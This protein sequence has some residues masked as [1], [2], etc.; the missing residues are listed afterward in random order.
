MVVK[1]NL[2]AL[3][4]SGTQQRLCAELECLCKTHPGLTAKS[5]EAA[6]V[7]LDQ[8]LKD[9]FRLGTGAIIV[10]GFSAR[11][12]LGFLHDAQHPQ[13]SNLFRSDIC[14]EEGWRLGLLKQ[15]ADWHKARGNLASPAQTCARLGRLSVM[16]CDYGQSVVTHDPAALFDALDHTRTAMH[17]PSFWRATNQTWRAFFGQAYPTATQFQVDYACALAFCCGQY[18]PF[19]P[20]WRDLADLNPESLFHFVS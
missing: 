17:D 18:F 19:D 16:I 2:E 4:K 20:L 12:G 5:A 7:Y 14:E 10:G 6:T 13:L 8:A 11:F 9:R 1:F 3:R 15:W